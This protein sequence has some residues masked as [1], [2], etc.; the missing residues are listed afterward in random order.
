[1][2]FLV[3]LFRLGDHVRNRRAR[4][5]SEG[6]LTI[7]NVG[8]NTSWC[9]ESSDSKTSLSHF[10]CKSTLRSKLNF[11]FTTP[12]Q[13]LKDWILSNVRSSYFLDLA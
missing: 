9:V 1:M 13:F 7:L 8:T 3:Y 6:N 10:L 5:K 4:F 12:K 2:I 11:E